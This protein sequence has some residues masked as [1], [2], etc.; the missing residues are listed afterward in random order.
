MA[1]KKQIKNVQKGKSQT[2]PRH[3]FKPNI[4]FA[5]ICAVVGFALYAN[6]IKHDY[7]LDDVG[8]ITGNEYVMEGIN[9]IPKILDRKSTRLNSSHSRASRMPSS[10]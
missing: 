3:T 9:G 5:V 1:Q 10:A 8:A 6:T 2:T 4:W 7:V